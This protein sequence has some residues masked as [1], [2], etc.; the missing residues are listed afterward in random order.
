MTG[1]D[2]PRSMTT[3]SAR[4]TT[5]TRP[6]APCPGRPA[7]WRGRPA[8]PAASTASASPARGDRVPA[9]C[10]AAGCRRRSCGLR[11]S[12]ERR[13]RA[14]PLS[15]EARLAINLILSRTDDG[16]ATLRYEETMERY[17]GTGGQ[18]Y[19]TS[20]NRRIASRLTTWPLP[21]TIDSQERRSP[22]TVPAALS[23]PVRTGSVRG[24]LP[25]A[26]L[27]RCGRTNG[28]RLRATRSGSPLKTCAAAARRSARPRRG[29]LPAR[30]NRT[31]RALVRGRT[32]YDTAR[33]DERLARRVAVVPD[34]SWA[35]RFLINDGERQVELKGFMRL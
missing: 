25:A 19:A 35:V 30:R 20:R 6:R 22:S 3:T 7:S 15:A 31:A 2:R 21:S 33:P 18:G 14:R 17:V 13:R 23:S 5:P 9:G 28:P 34:T 16:H 27:G 29:E 32:G 4:W 26:W 1:H 12:G 8:R 10:G 24:S 11:R